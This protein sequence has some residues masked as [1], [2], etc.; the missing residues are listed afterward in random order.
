MTLLTRQPGLARASATAKLGH[1]TQSTLVHG[2]DV[3]F[4]RQ[5]LHGRW[6]YK[7]CFSLIN[8]EES[9]SLSC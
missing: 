3:S 6:K 1:Y 9:C 2:Q 5:Q 8:R 4:Q 7:H